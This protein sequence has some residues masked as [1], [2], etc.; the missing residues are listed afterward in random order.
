[1][2]NLLLVSMMQAMELLFHNH[3]QALHDVKK[4][5]RMVFDE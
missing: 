4:L 3:L 1:M 5:L 2:A